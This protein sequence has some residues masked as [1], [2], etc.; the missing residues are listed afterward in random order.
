MRQSASSTRLDVSTLKPGDVLEGRYRYVQ[1]IGKG[2][3]GTVLLMEDT[4]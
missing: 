3:F 1:K 2:A 4:W